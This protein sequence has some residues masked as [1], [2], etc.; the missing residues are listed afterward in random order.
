LLFAKTEGHLPWMLPLA[1]AEGRET[2]EECEK[3]LH[4]G[5]DWDIIN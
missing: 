5:L 4:D 2:V 3:R 1:A